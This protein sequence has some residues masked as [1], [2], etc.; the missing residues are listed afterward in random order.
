MF[1]LRLLRPPASAGSQELEYLPPYGYFYSSFN[2][3]LSATMIPRTLFA[4]S[5]VPL[6]PRSRLSWTSDWVCKSC[7][8]KNSPRVRFASSQTSAV[9][10]YYI[11]TPIFYVN[12]GKEMRHMLNL[13]IANDG[14]SPPRWSSIYYGSHRYPQTMARLEWR[15][16][17][18]LHWNG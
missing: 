15:G 12:A 5:H 11:T 2:R 14:F 3:Q 6:R 13:A 7:R 16:G 18:P 4:V 1:G 10:P 9:K 8:T 17:N